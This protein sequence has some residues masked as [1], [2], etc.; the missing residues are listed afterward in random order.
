MRIAIAIFAFVQFASAAEYRIS[1]AAELVKI[2]K[3]L[4]PGDA[5][6]LKDGDW[7]NQELIVRARGTEAQPI[8]FRAETAGK[9][10]VTG[11]SSIEIDG[12][13]VVVADFD[14]DLSTGDRPSTPARCDA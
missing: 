5:V 7:R 11:Q 2:T 12:E 3:D 10:I 1:S 8:T 4:K 13:H 6:I 9:V 14:Q